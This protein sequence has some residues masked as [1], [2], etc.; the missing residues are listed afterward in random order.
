MHYLVRKFRKCALRARKLIRYLKENNRGFSLI[1]LMVVIAII[2]ILAGIGIPAY[3]SLTTRTKSIHIINQIQ[4]IKTGVE[5]YYQQYGYFPGDDPYAST[6]FG[7][8]CKVGSATSIDGD[9]DGKIN[10]VVGGTSGSVDSYV[11]LCLMGKGE[12]GY[13]S[14]N[15]TPLDNFTTKPTPGVTL[16]KI[17][18]GVGLLG[19]G[20]A[21]F[22]TNNVLAI[23][24]ITGTIT[25]GDVLASIGNDALTV[26]EV[27]KI[28]AHFE[29]NSKPNEGDVQAK[30]ATT[31]SCFATATG[32]YNMEN[33][34]NRVCGL[35]VK[36]P[37]S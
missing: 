37:R 14:D 5:Q 2:G 32:A 9:G 26:A 6:R 21:P 10:F 16:P 36:L 33:K 29:P 12:L 8:K 11:A 18:D 28:K 30:N 31:D 27:Q 22:S 13:L 20:A 3:T 7:P 19:Y 15:L 24:T 17:G 34:N 1:E 4:Q 23:G 35:M 25:S